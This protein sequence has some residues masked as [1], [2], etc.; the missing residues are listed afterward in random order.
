MLAVTGTNGKS[1]T[2][3]LLAG[4]MQAHGLG[5]A[6]AGNVESIQGGPLSALPPH[7]GWVV[8]E[9]S[10]FQAESF[11]ALLPEA[12]IFTN[13]ENGARRFLGVAFPDGAR[14]V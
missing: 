9:V 12:A 8:A 5:A 3:G 7:S 11:V 10:S 4:V 13:R 6:V 1:T 14:G 2:V